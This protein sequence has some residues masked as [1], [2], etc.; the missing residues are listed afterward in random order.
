MSD[1]EPAPAQAASPALPP[2]PPP[3]PAPDN[4]EVSGADPEVDEPAGHDEPDEVAPAGDGSEP[5]GDE[6]DQDG[7]YF[8]QLRRAMSDEGGAA[9]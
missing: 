8:E 6:S 5:A 2:P 7:D 1:E 4:D 3:P 9:S